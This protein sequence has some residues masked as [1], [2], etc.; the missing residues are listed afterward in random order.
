MTLS[1]QLA[2]LK[3]SKKA[4]F[5]AQQKSAKAAAD[6]GRTLS[7]EE[8]TA[9]DAA[10]AE[11]DSIDADIARIEKM[12]ATEQADAAP[13]NKAAAQP[14]HVFREAKNTPDISNGIGFAKAARC[15]ALGALDRCD[16]VQ[17]AKSLYND[18]RVVNAVHG[19]LYKTAVT[20]VD[21]SALTTG[22]AAADFAEYLMPLTI[23]GKLSM[24]PAP[25]RQ[26]LISQTSIGS[27]AWVGE[28]KPVPVSKPGFARKTLEPLKVAALAVSSVETLRD[29]SPAAD[30]LIRDSITEALQWRL[31]SDF[32]DPANAGTATVKPASI[33]YGL[34]LTAS[35][36]TDAAHVRTDLKALI[37]AFIAN[38]RPLTGAAFVTDAATALA[39]SLMTNE[40]G[41]PY[42]PGVGL[43]GGT[44]LGLPL[45]A[46]TYVPKDANSDS[47][48]FL[49]DAASYF[50]NKGAVE[51]SIST[52]ASIEMSDAP[53]GEGT[54]T[55][56]FQNGMAGFLATLP[57]N[58][59][60]RRDNSIAGVDGIAYA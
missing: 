31:D 40:N 37:A 35:S 43:N 3:A 39:I 2:K 36:G 53:T 8:Q 60:A 57:V 50:F 56:L 20:P 51:L 22:Q 1:E 28:G 59:T 10:Q 38:N 49:V 48:M 34:T 47:Q 17:V 23:V 13:V 30:A 33:S 29:S 42:F 19:M 41:V 32:I 58:W 24:R 52:E 7:T 6:E 15:L 25:F 16:A 5:E 26:P 11:I 44:L 4:A 27:A 55:S 54:L 12:L 18:E 45:I 21:G 9:V 46:S 14:G